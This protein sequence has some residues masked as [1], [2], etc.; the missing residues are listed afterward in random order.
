MGGLAVSDFD[1]ALPPGRIAQEPAPRR[2]EARLMVCRRDSGEAAHARFGEIARFIGAPALLVLN[3]TKVIP[4]RL[5]GRRERTR[6]KAEILLLREIGP[7]T[8]ECLLNPSASLREGEAVV[9]DGS[10]MRAVVGGRPSPDTRAVRLEGVP[11]P[12]AEACRIGA[13]PLPPYIRRPDGETAADRERYQTVYARR[14]GAVAAPTAGLHFTERLLGE[15]DAAGVGI[16]RLAL[17]VGLGT[18][19][20]VR[21]ERLEDV[22]LHAEYFEIGEETAAAINRA[23]R[24][25]A[26]IVA[27]GTTTA[28]A[29]EAAADGRGE[30]APRRGWTDLFI[31]PPYRF[32]IVENLLTN[33]HLPRSTLLMLVAALTGRE[34]LLSL[35]DEAVRAGYRFYSYGDAMLILAGGG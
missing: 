8:W 1:Y 3:D 30:V 29:L 14:P 17:H 4:A 19:G 5:R 31:R 25:G 13:P 12:L 27:V 23:R 2:E 20:P 9:F 21:A 24:A 32:R 22:R 35:Y 10:A 28:R 18:F 34:R 16:A 33:F 7:G 26:R 15:L 11:D 6:G